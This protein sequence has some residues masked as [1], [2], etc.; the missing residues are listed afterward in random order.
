V[1]TSKIRKQLTCGCRTWFKNDA[2]VSF[3]WF[4]RRWQNQRRLCMCGMIV[5]A[6]QLK[7]RHLWLRYKWYLHI[8]ISPSSKGF[9]LVDLATAEYTVVNFRR[10]CNWLPFNARMRQQPGKERCFITKCVSTQ[11]L[12]KKSTRLLIIGLFRVQSN[13]GSRSITLIG[14][15]QG[16]TFEG[17]YEWKEKA[18]I[19]CST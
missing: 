6:R 7:P 13:R 18:S 8:W 15:F 19:F 4:Y 14:Q 3:L 1:K 12:W 16:A 5:K 17:L 9:I 10:I 11:S 2:W